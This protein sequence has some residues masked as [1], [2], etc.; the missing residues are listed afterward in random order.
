MSLRANS[1][2]LDLAYAVHTEVGNHCVGDASRLCSSAD[3][4]ASD[5]RPAEILTNKNA[6]PSSRLMTL[7]R[8]RAQKNPQVFPQENKSDDAER[9]RVLSVKELQRRLW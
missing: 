6:R 4:Y 9:G 5:G 8:P 3:A 7:R 2:P 1:T